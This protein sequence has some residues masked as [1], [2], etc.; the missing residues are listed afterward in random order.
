MI[1]IAT[2]QIDVIPGNIRENWKQIEEEIR[3]AREKGTHILVLPE[4][5]LTGYLIGDLWD[6][7]AFLRE[8]EAYNEKIA[9]TARGITIL[10]GSCAIDWEK[11]NDDGRPRKYNAAFAAADG[12]FL[13]PENGS[14]PMS[15]KPFFP[16]T[17]AS[18]TGAI[19]PPFSRRQWKKIFP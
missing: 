2:A 1:K 5:C 3:M 12:H 4:M 14:H 6:Q 8:C 9:A 17:A 15:S 18:M 19:S 13:V 7:S 16:I 11:T 10:W